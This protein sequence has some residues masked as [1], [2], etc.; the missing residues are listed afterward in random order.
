MKIRLFIS[1]SHKDEGSR[2]KLNTCIG[3]LKNLNLVEDWHDRM[4]AGG[5]EWEKEIDRYL[6]SADVILLLVSPDFL[7]S[8]YCFGVE[9]RRALE[10]HKADEARVIPIIVRPALWDAVDELNR[11]QALPEGATPVTDPNWSNEDT[12]WENVCRGIHK[13]IEKLMADRKRNSELLEQIK[14]NEFKGKPLSPDDVKKYHLSEALPYFLLG[15]DDMKEAGG[16]LYRMVERSHFRPDIIIGINGGGMVVATA[17]N[18]GYQRPIGVIDTRDTKVT[19][20]SLPYAVELVEPYDRKKVELE[21]KRILV[22]DTKLK[23]GGALQKVQTILQN[24]YGK[25]TTIRYAIALGY[26]GWDFSRWKVIH[27]TGFHWPV[28]FRLKHLPVYV[29]RYTK[30]DPNNDNIIEEL[31]PGWERA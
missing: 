3:F 12:A 24:E 26:G 27:E 6:N 16:A 10:R 5:E 14:P 15:V 21:R 17:M 25:D 20:V 23:S 7:N 8:R 11:L 28:Q 4:I 19:Y 2:K 9:M 31:H 29:A 13:T 30:T 22:T 1:Y 18:V